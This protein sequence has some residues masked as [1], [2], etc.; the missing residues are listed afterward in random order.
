MSI[1]MEYSFQIGLNKTSL[2]TWLG[3][4]NTTEWRRRRL[5][6]RSTNEA[7][8]A[9]EAGDGK[10]IPSPEPSAMTSTPT[11]SNSHH[12]IGGAQSLGTGIESSYLNTVDVR[13]VLCLTMKMG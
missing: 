13:E 6:G 7:L 3:K 12:L 9:S 2:T 11:D 10:A 4:L 8:R 5:R 1:K